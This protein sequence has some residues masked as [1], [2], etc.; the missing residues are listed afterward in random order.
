MSETKH[1]EGPWSLD[2]VWIGDEPEYHVSSPDGNFIGVFSSDEFDDET[3]KANGQLG[4]AA[5]E[6]LVACEKALEYIA[7]C[8]EPSC[9]EGD[10]LED[11]TIHDGTTE[12][13]NL[14]RAAIMKATG[15]EAAW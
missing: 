7:R 2:E 6:L 14:L 1:T 12:E 4:A 11:G 13:G 10:E 9:D 5:P 8:V 3:N 15:Q